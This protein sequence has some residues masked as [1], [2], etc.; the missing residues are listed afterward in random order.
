MTAFDFALGV[1]LILL[2]GSLLYKALVHCISKLFSEQMYVSLLFG[3]NLLLHS[4]SSSKFCPSADYSLCRFA[5]K[6]KPL[7][8]S[9]V[10]SITVLSFLLGALCSGIAGY[11]GMWV[12][13]RAN[14]RVSS[15]ARRSARE[16]L[17]VH[18]STY[19]ISAMN[20]CFMNNLDTKI[21]CFT[22]T[23]KHLLGIHV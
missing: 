1:V 11:V 6:G 8:R 4:N 12:S 21:K 3:Y 14:V 22:D 15:A 10:A 19:I 7:C 2:S 13:V 16:A 5:N 20:C 9:T 17:Q 23:E 18:P